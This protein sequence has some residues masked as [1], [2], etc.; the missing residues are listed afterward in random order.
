M[1]DLIGT[2]PTHHPDGRSLVPFLTGSPAANWRDAVHWEFDFRDVAGQTTERWF[3]RSS[4]QLSLAVIRTERWKYVHF[5]TLPPLLFDLQSDPGNLNNLAEDPASAAIRLEM[6]ERL[7][8]WRAE[9]L[10]QTLAL[11]ELTST[12]V[13]TSPL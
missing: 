11:T 5:A 10:D 6:A 2:T 4:T 1:L 3:G 8:R 13:V 9:H 7:L 12:G